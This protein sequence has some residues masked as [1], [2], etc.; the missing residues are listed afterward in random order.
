MPTLT[1]DLRSEKEGRFSRG[2]II[3]LDLTTGMEMGAVQFKNMYWAPMHMMKLYKG[4]KLLKLVCKA[5][6]KKK[7][8]MLLYQSVVRDFSIILKFKLKPKAESNK[9]PF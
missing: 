8:H 4:E 9:Y 1:A 7:S 3:S 5:K 2:H 6:K